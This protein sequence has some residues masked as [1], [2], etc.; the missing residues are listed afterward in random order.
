MEL[1]P[2]ENEAHS[3][4]FFF[5]GHFFSSP[6]EVK[7]GKVIGWHSSR[8]QGSKGDAVKAIGSYRDTPRRAWEITEGVRFSDIERAKRGGG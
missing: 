3:T 8:S 5:Q 2:I 4:G 1:L 6:E 7:A